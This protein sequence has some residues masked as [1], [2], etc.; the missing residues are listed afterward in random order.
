VV[1]LKGLKKFRDLIW[2]FLIINFLIITILKNEKKI[3]EQVKL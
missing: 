1:S 3:I 2:S